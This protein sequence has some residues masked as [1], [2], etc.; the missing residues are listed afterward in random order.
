VESDYLIVLEVPLRAT[1]KPQKPMKKLILISALFLLN[2]TFTNAQ[3]SDEMK[4]SEAVSILKKALVDADKAMLDKILHEDLSYGH[5]NGL[6]ETKAMLIE[7][8]VSNNSDFKTMD[9][10]EQTI[11][12]VGKNAIVRH[13]IFAETSNKGVAGITK[14]NVLLVFTKVKGNWILLARQA[15]KI[16]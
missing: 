5:S 7:S 2:F 14:L 3:S 1:V 8:L 10:T 4:V 6:I 16:V 15:A 12:I 9:L 13:K 11:K